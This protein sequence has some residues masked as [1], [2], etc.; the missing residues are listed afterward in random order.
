MIILCVFE[1][2]LYSKAAQLHPEELARRA[3]TLGI[4]EIL[5]GLVNLP[6]LIC[7]IILLIQAGKVSR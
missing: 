1:L 5:V 6:T 3:K 7:G 2:S 4:F